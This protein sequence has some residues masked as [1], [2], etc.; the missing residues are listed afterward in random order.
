LLELVVGFCEELQQTPLAVT[1]AFPSS[2]TFPPAV[3]VSCVI[4]VTPE[5]V[6]IARVGFGLQEVRHRVNPIKRTGIK[7]ILNKLFIGGFF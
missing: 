2:D 7:I 6:T 3:A 1:S 5:V 4:P